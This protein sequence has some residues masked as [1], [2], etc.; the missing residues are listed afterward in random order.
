MARVLEKK[1]RSLGAQ[2]SIRGDRA[3]SPKRALIRKPYPPGQHGKQYRRKPSEFGS[4]LREKQKL[5]FSYGLTNKQL[6]K[7]FQ[8]AAKS[9]D[10]AIKIITNTLEGRLDNVIMRLGFVPSR[11]IGKQIVSH[12]H[13]L[14]NGKK[15]TTSSYAVRPGDVITIKP[16]SRNIS[17]FQDLGEKLKSY[18]TPP[19]LSLN[20]TTFEGKVESHP[21]DVEFPFNINL[22]VDYYSKK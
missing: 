2:L 22:I 3:V 14:V 9:K 19:W 12:G 7:I 4:Q 1:E 17:F 5:K 11:S 10:S 21:K 13:I 15:V 18:D 6:K 16:A 8:D 20:T